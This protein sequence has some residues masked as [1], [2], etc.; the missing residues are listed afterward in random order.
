MISAEI[1]Q[2]LP[3]G[4]AL[5][6][7]AQAF[8]GLCAGID[9]ESLQVYVEHLA[10]LADSDLVL[11]Y[12]APLGRS[13]PLRLV[14][15]SGLAA[16]VDSKFQTL[17]TEQT[18]G[19][20]GLR[21]ATGAIGPLEYAPLTAD[22]L[23]M[24]VRTCCAYPVWSDGALTGQLFFGS[25]RWDRFHGDTLA[26]FAAATQQVAQAL[27]RRRSATAG[28]QPSWQGDGACGAADRQRQ[29][30]AVLAHE[31]RNPIAPI[32]SGLDILATD[33][34]DVQG[35]QSTLDMMQ[36]QV[37]HLVRLIDD[38]L[39]TVRLDTGRLQV[40]REPVA[41]KEV[42]RSA[43]ESIRPA[44]AAKHQALDLDDA[45]AEVV[46]DVDPVRLSQAFVNILSANVKQT[47]AGGAISVS[48]QARPS[49]L[50]ITFEDEGAGIDPAE[51]SN[52]FDLFPASAAQ[53]S[54]D[55]LG[56]GLALVRG[57]VELNDGSVDLRNREA[58]D[59]SAYV[60]TLPRTELVV[61]PSRSEAGSGANPV[62]RWPSHR[63]LVVDDNQ[64]ASETLGLLLELDGHTVRVA[65]D[66]PSSVAEAREFQPEIVLMDIGLPGFN[67]DEATRQIRA[68]QALVRPTIIALT[69][70]G[71]A[72]DREATRRAG[73]DL[74]LVK[75]VAHDKIRETIRGLTESDPGRST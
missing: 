18:A 42:V 73:C 27:V 25:R 66:G 40:K 45:A 55:G 28:Q 6:L 51:L 12:H 68:Q 52:V 69:G 2:P 1:V 71:S 36:R 15:Q 32:R 38:L 4:S 67:G 70:W 24:R 30:I 46:V 72:A 31:L 39:D 23:D 17:G 3:D 56:I 49:E 60:V 58:R 37:A 63:V 7:F 61:S 14:A 48:V 33:L 47:P 65:H 62:H 19:A 50:V 9:E 41:L 53:K 22:L 64:D 59:G 26:V 44:L 20:G 75:P 74:H 43:I 35:R 57:L 11:V 54:Q 29:F 16:G 21:A 34:L 5:G 8:V 10:Q 13:G